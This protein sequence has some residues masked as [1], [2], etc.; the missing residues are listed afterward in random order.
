[1]G[2]NGHPRVPDH[3]P[4][5][6]LDVQSREEEEARQVER[7]GAFPLP[8]TGRGGLPKWA[9]RGGDLLSKFF[10]SARFLT[11]RMA[12]LAGRPIWRGMLSKE[13]VGW[14]VRGQMAK[15]Y[16]KFAAGFA[17]LAGLALLAGA[18]I[19]L[20]PT[21]SDFLKFK[22]GST[23]VDALT[24]MQQLAVFLAREATEET[25]DESGKTRK[26]SRADVGER[27]IR[28]KLAPIPG[29]VVNWAKK[30]N[31]VGEEVTLGSTVRDLTI[32]LSYQETGDIYRHQG[33]LKG[34]VIELLNLMG[35]GTQDY[36][37]NERRARR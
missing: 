5:D 8:P 2:E 36:E 14:K 3:G 13:S 29:A 23:R 11:S 25:T 1:M 26:A 15:Q 30:R 27:F 34:T 32:P 7:R 19:N 18:T 28:S 33:P 24:G 37:A 31:I 16:A 35:M 9:E 20:N 10:F 12:L 21:S 17:S 4:Q 22:F 6:Q